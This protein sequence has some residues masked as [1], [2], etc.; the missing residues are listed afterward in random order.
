[1][2]K[3]N[4]LSVITPVYNGESMIE[5]SYWCLCSQSVLDWEWV[6]VDD[7]STD[8]SHEILHRI[9][10][11]DE[12]V[13]VITYK[14]NRGR[15]YARTKLLENARSDWVALWDIDDFYMP[16]RLER[17]NIARGNGAEYYTSHSIVLDLSLNVIG[18]RGRGYAL[19]PISTP[20]IIHAATAARKDL[21]ISIG[22]NPDLETVG[23]IGEDAAVVYQLSLNAKGYIDPD[24]TF[25]HVFGNEVFLRKSV[26][27]NRVQIRVLREMWNRGQLPVS[28]GMYRQMIRRRATRLMMLNMLQVAPPMYNWIS[29][30]R[31]KSAVEHSLELQPFRAQYIQTIRDRFAR[32]DW[33]T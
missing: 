22:Y 23:Q 9:S 13:R 28:V 19:K 17:V 5:R 29:T 2:D 27:S 20:I 21:L 4:L 14:Q 24:P 8:R 7:G 30:R 32:N 16:D 6:V 18:I 3:S 25:I 1:M 11:K 10:Q 12:R 33:K 26:H 15:G 31:R